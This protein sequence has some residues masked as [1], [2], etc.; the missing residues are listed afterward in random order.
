MDNTIALL[1]LVTSL[2]AVI[3]ALMTLY[4]T[5][6]IPHKIMI[7][8]RYAELLTEYRSTEMG[9]AI[10]SIFDFIDKDC[11]KQSDPDIIKERYIKRFE[12]EIKEKLHNE[13]DNTKKDNSEKNIL[14]LCKY[15]PKDTL[16]FKRRLVD[17][18]FWL[19]ADLRFNPDYPIKISKERLRQYFSK[20][21]RY[22]LHILYHLNKA[23]ESKE[24]QIDASLIDNCK[25][26]CPQGGNS[27][28]AQ[29]RRKLYEESK[30]WRLGGGS[31]GRRDD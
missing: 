3:T 18:L 12:K 25:C 11:N 24:C 23:S 8:Q 20:N 16:H 30:S 14:E 1:S 7:E 22:L 27:P 10:F 17:H 4:V 19:V 9:D 6:R 28:M 21:E 31:V 5:W 15:D 29:Y 13:K 26:G 2:F